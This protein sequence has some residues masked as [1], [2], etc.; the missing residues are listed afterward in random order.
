MTVFYR[1]NFSQLWI[2]LQ[3]NE[4]L[5]VLDS[6][7]LEDYFGVD[8]QV[9]LLHVPTGQ[10]FAV[11]MVEVPQETPAVPHDVFQGYRFLSALPD[12]EY[13][14]QCRVRDVLGNYTVVGDVASPRGDERRIA[15][16]FEVRPGAPRGIG[17]VRHM[18]RGFAPAHHARGALRVAERAWRVR[19]AERARGLEAGQTAR[20][21]LRVRQNAIGGDH[22]L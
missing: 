16:S 7:Y 18:A 21:V 15:L 10:R 1:Q 4:A 12:G 5:G 2:K 8:G 19:V 3:S 17:G 14:V 22:E 20:P 11:L 9:S 13:Q 6:D